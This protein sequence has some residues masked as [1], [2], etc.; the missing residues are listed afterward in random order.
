MAQQMKKK[1]PESKTR[2]RQEFC[3]LGHVSTEWVKMA[4]RVAFISTRPLV[5]LQELA[6]SSTEHHSNQSSVVSRWIPCC[7]S[8]EQTE[9]ET[10][11][12]QQRQTYT[13]DLFENEGQDMQSLRSSQIILENM[14]VQLR[15]TMNY[16]AMFEYFFGQL[17]F[18][19]FTRSLLFI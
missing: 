17:D 1:R 7:S 5:A 14:L 2:P 15:K 13:A 16:R 12:S 9:A 3:P 10:L 6:S 11:S 8:A 19:C 4:T 18:L